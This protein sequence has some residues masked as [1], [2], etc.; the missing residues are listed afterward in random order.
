MPVALLALVLLAGPQEH[1]DGP[2]FKVGVVT[3]GAIAGADIAT[4]A[5]AAERGGY[6][7]ANPVYRH[8]FKEPALLGLVNGAQSTGVLLVVAKW[9]KSDNRT[10]RIAARVILGATI[11]FRGYVVLHNVRELRRSE[12]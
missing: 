2:L 1:R 6:R 4:T 3:L 11:A 7:E 5:Q 12:R 9:H 8:L 10:K